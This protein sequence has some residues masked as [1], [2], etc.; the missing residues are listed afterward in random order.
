MVQRELAKNVPAPQSE[1][2]DEM[3]SK[4]RS[5]E[6]DIS[7]L[8]TK[9]TSHETK[10]EGVASQLRGIWTQTQDPTLSMFPRNLSRD[11]LPVHQ[12]PPPA[13]QHHLSHKTQ[14]VNQSQNNIQP[15]T[16]RAAWE[17]KE[18]LELLLCFDSNGK[19][20]VVWKMMKRM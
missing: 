20:S 16:G 5:M 4:F 14:P 1:G 17:N 19:H 6:S 12:P 11:P 9:S 8:K 18:C 3:D 13:L 2:T 7:N 10:L 15:N